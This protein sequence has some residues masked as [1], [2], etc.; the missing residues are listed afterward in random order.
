VD[1]AELIVSELGSNALNHTASGSDFGTFHP[2]LSPQTV[3]ISLSDAGGCSESHITEA[4]PYDTPRPRIKHP[5][6]P[7]LPS[8][9]HQ[10]PARPHRH[11][12]ARRTQGGSHCMLRPLL[13]PGYWCECWTLSPATDPG[14]VLL[15]SIE[16]DSPSET[17]RW[18]RVTVRTIAAALDQSRARCCGVIRS[19]G[20]PQHE[21]R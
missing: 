19:V 4:D 6:G 5:H 13:R 10:Q 15:A 7:R 1:D 17:T 12:P 20:H 3:A 16:T 2:T 14:S 21:A 8:G 18:I 9:H 11:R